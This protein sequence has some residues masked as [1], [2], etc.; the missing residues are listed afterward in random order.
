[1]QAGKAVK[2]G[3]SSRN[4]RLTDAPFDFGVSGFSN[5]LEI[6]T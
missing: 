1:M 6:T 5:P 3:K 4:K 2:S